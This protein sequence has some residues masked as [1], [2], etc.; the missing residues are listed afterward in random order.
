MDQLF[1]VHLFKQKFLNLYR[2]T[3]KVVLSC[4]FPS[5]SNHIIHGNIIIFII[6]IYYYYELK[7]KLSILSHYSTHYILTCIQYKSY[8]KVNRMR[9]LWLE[10]ESRNLSIGYNITLQQILSHYKLKSYNKITNLSNLKITYVSIVKIWR[11]EKKLLEKYT[12][13]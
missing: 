13:F 2:S 6:C 10:V 3:C 12:L 9:G 5:D 8:H 4:H 11:R 7:F 1:Y